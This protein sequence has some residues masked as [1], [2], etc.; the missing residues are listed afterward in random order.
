MRIPHYLSVS[1]HGILYLRFPVPAYLHPQGHRS[2]IKLSLNTRC[3]KEALLL[4]RLL[5]YVGTTILKN[6]VIANMTYLEIRQV[7]TQH[8][9]N[10]LNKRQLHFEQQG[11]LPVLDRA[12]L[13]STIAMADHAIEEK[14]YTYLGND[15]TVNKFISIYALSAQVILSSPTSMPSG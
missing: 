8:F 15:E 11:R 12:A 2:Y 9:T 14:D 7:L 10:L 13:K 6:P 1:R 3:P 4:S 5:M